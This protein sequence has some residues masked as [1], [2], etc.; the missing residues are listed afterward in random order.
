MDEHNLGSNE[1][2]HKIIEGRKL[3]SCNIILTSRPHDTETIEKFFP[4]HIRIKGFSRD[5]ASQFISRCV[6]N[7]HKAKV[8]LRFTLKN[9]A[10]QTPSQVYFSPMLVLFL[11]ILVK[12]DELDLTVRKVIPLSEIYFRIVRC[13]YRKYCERTGNEYQECTFVDLW[14][15]VCKLAWKMWKSGKS[16]AKRSDVIKEVGEDAFKIGLLI[17]HKDFRLS[18]SET[19]DISITFIHLNLQQFLG[20][21]GF[22]QM[23][24]ESQSIDS[25]LSD[26]LEVQILE[27]RI[28]MRFCLWFLNGSFEF[29]RREAVL[30]SLTSHYTKQ[31]NL[32]Q[33]DMM[34]IGKLFPVLQIPTTCIDEN[35][36]VLNFIC[37]VLS[38]CNRTVE[39]FLPSI[40]SYTIEYLSELISN[41]PPHSLQ[42]ENRSK[43][44]LCTVL[45]IASNLVGLQKSSNCCEAAGLHPSFFLYCDSDT[46]LS[47]LM[48][49]S[50][51]QL[52]LFAPHEGLR[53][54]LVGQ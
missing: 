12:S 53:R 41:L 42:S 50:A 40:P 25:L 51:K 2:V 43:T 31:V 1:D 33:L 8:V 34:D 11:T 28:F 5:H 21:F 29:S 54:V 46:D 13:I 3:L 18:G 44:N 27:S 24:N 39:F 47:K 38:K 35:I 17:G 23:L 15:R 37:G 48:L 22:L 16:W 45:E 26:G 19:A 20:T 7:S 52:S 36:P 30:D 14:K 4:T 9:F 49:Q 32:V 10:C 6:S